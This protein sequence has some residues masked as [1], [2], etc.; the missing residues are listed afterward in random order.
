MKPGYRLIAGALL[1]L[2]VAL[3]GQQ[4]PPAQ[5]LEWFRQHQLAQQQSLFTQ[6]RWQFLGPTNIS[7]RMTDVA[8]VTPKGQ[9]YTIYVAGA[10]GGV[11]RTRNEGVTWE[12]I[13]DQEVTTAIGDVTLAPSDQ[14]IIY[15]GT[16]EPNLFRSSNAGAGLWKSTDEGRTWTHMGLVGTNTIARII[17]HPTNPDIVWVAAGGN[18]WTANPDRGVYKSTDGGRTWEKVLYVNDLTGANDL[19]IDPSNP[20]VLYATTWQRVRRK[21]NDPRVEEGFKESGVYKSTNGG[22]TWSV[23]NNGL[24]APHHRGRIGI[25]I[26]RSNPRVVYAFVD[27]YEIARQ[28]AAG[29][30]DAY[31]RPAAA[32]IRG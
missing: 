24:P 15:V 28:P 27:N 29:Q 6:P 20:N 14:R 10:T 32:I 4:T 30:T 3:A 25:D 13:F 9:N 8:V 5:R 11:W 1:L 23:I 19:V 16:G 7:G 17:V 2:P 31:G 26:A 12:P 21:W 18:E 22:R